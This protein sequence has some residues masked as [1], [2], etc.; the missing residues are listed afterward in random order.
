M[1]FVPSNH[2]SQ[3]HFAAAMREIFIL[4]CL[5]VGCQ[6]DL[7]WSF[8]VVPVGKWRGD[9]TTQLPA[10]AEK[11]IDKRRSNANVEKY[12]QLRELIRLQKTGAGYEEMKTKSINSSA[13][14]NREKKPS[15]DRLIG[16]GNLDQRL[17]AI[18]SFKRSSIAAESSAGLNKAEEDELTELMETDYEDDITDD[19]DDEAEYESAVLRAIEDN[20]RNELAARIL[21]EQKWDERS[22][23]SK[24]NRDSSALS[25]KNHPPQYTDHARE[26]SIV[27][28]MSDSTYGTKGNR[29]NVDDKD[30]YTP[31]VSTW[32]IYER[33]RDISKTYGGGRSISRA[34]MDKLDAE[35]EAKEV[36][37]SIKAKVYFTE[38]MKVEEEHK[39]KSKEALNRARGYLHA[40]N[41]NATVRIL[42]EVK[43]LVSWHSEFGGEVLL[44]YG[45]ALE[46]V[47][48]VEEARKVYGKLASNSWS[49]KVR[50]QALGLISGLDIT[51]QIRKQVSNSTKPMFDDMQMA[52]VSSAVAKGLRNDWNDFKKDSPAKDA[53]VRPWFDDAMSGPLRSLKV[54]S[55]SDAYFLLLRELDPLKK[56][57]SEALMRAFRKFYLSSFEEKSRFIRS[58]RPILVNN[59]YVG[60]N[61]SN[62]EEM[63]RMVNGSWEIVASLYDISPFAA[64]RYEIGDVRRVVNV[65]DGCVS[66]TVP[67]FWGMSSLTR[68]GTVEWN[69]ARCELRMAGED[70]KKFVAPWQNK[71]RFDQTVQVSRH[72]IAFFPDCVA[73]KIALFLM[74][75]L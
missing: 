40:G 60:L 31:K 8:I 41:R 1:S 66:E 51:K 75:C 12:L 55:L 32:G 20:R 30:L 16:K 26:S 56:V 36:A 54:A 7:S 21:G 67:V 4:L 24:Q 74:W 45:M 46:T 53:V 38:S 39:F 44:E 48:R 23:A 49:T 27:Q 50:R 64:R 15:Y 29:N 73:C 13:P 19:D 70:I 10:K 35:M 42:E 22:F 71:A 25:T 61:V 43:D 33:P 72:H 11:R 65:G 37:S 2:P 47:E 59:A 58:R 57:P 63:R 5:V 34:E 6:L 28:P 52:I 62:G 69:S 3:R 17:R 18:V 9:V 14:S 68:S